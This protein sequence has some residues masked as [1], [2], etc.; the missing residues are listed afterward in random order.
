M[1]ARGRSDR[2]AQIVERPCRYLR[3]IAD[4]GSKLSLTP[5]RAARTQA[6]APIPLAIHPKLLNQHMQHILERGAK[7]IAPE[8]EVEV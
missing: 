4:C 1:A 6:I 5:P 7:P 3:R 8:R 2:I